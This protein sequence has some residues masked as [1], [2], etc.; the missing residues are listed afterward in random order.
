MSTFVIDE[1]LRC[2]VS[3]GLALH[4][5]LSVAVQPLASANLHIRVAFDVG[6]VTAT[7]DVANFAYSEDG[8]VIVVNALYSVVIRHILIFFIRD[9]SSVVTYCERGNCCTILVGILGR[10]HTILHIH[11]DVRIA[12]DHSLVATAK[13][14]TNLG[15]RDDVQHGVGLRVAPEVGLTQSLLLLFFSGVR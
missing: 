15:G 13:D 14:F 12:N 7:E 6:E 8:I 10:H 3:R 1:R 5:A 11:I 4:L 2:G 9:M